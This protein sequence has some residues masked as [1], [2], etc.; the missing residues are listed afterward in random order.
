M[1]QRE[2]AALKH[3]VEWEHFVTEYPDVAES[4]ADFVDH[5][6]AAL[7]PTFRVAEPAGQKD[8]EYA[9]HVR[10]LEPRIREYRELLHRTNMR[11]VQERM[12]TDGL[13]PVAAVVITRELLG[14]G[15]HSLE[16]ARDIVLGDPAW[17]RLARIH[18]RTGAWL[19]QELERLQEAAVRIAPHQAGRP[20]HTA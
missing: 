13:P 12:H 3:S 6:E 20:G 7:A 14:P 18:R 17:H 11:A 8:G 10:W 4:E 1:G 15:R 9:R 16:D 2:I 19:D 5:L